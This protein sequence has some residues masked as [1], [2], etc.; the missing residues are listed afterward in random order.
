MLFCPFQPER[1]DRIEDVDA[2]FFTDAAH[3]FQVAVEI[4]GDLNAGGAVGDGLGQF[5]EGDL[6]VLEE[7]DAF[8]TRQGRIG[9]QGGGGVAGRGAGDPLHAQQARLGDA[10]GHAAVLEGAGRVLAFMFQPQLAQAGPGGQFRARVEV[11][12][13]FRP[14]E[15]LVVGQIGIN[16]FAIA[17]DAAVVGRPQRSKAPVKEFVRDGLSQAV[18]VMLDVQ[19][20]TA[21]D[22]GVGDLINRVL[23]VA[24]HALQDTLHQRYR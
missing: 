4:R 15:D 18:Q 17:P 21:G 13:A 19:Q 1:I 8:Q 24:V 10:S 23:T 7:D 12:V 9:G 5:A 6:P 22:A 2:K 11:R 20:A 3:Q 16:Q 14:R